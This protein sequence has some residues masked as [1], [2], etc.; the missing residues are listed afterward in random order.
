MDGDGTGRRRAA[1]VPPGPGGP[2]AFTIPL[3]TGRTVRAITPRVGPAACLAA[4]LLAVP[5]ARAVEPPAPPEGFGPSTFDAAAPPAEQYSRLA[6]EL[7]ETSALAEV[8]GTER[9]ALLVRVIEAYRGYQV[10]R[11]LRLSG[12]EGANARDWP[13]GSRWLL[14]LTPGSG[15]PLEI[16]P[17]G[18][19]NRRAVAAWSAPAWRH[20]PVVVLA[21]IA[22]RRAP[23]TGD[24]PMFGVVRVLRGEVTEREF[25]DYDREGEKVLPL[26]PGGTLYVLG[27]R[28]LFRPPGSKELLGTIQSMDPV[29]EA[30][31]PEIERLVRE[32]P[33]G[34]LRADLLREKGDLERL[35]T[36]FRFHR[37]PVVAEVRVA[38]IGGE[39]TNLGGTH[40]AYSAE[41]MIRGEAPAAGALPS[42]ERFDGFWEPAKGA[43]A[44]AEAPLPILFYGGGHGYYG[45]ERMGDRFLAAGYGPGGHPSARLPLDEANRAAAEAWLRQ[46]PPPFPC[47]RPDPAAFR[48]LSGCAALPRLAAEAGRDL[49]HRPL[50]LRAALARPERWTLFE[51]HG[52]NG[53]RHDHGFHW[54][55]RC[56]IPNERGWV[57]GWR[58]EADAAAWQF[59]FESDEGPVPWRQGERW[60][61]FWLDAGS[62]PPEG[63]AFAPG[64]FMKDRFPSRDGLQALGERLREIRDA[65]DAP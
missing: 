39:A 35:E 22:R 40:L 53:A 4:L 28:G 20:S 36:A 54:A 13:R 61:G 11:R 26:D 52:V 32:D 21:R 56:G 46:S 34:R 64:L 24:G 33:L 14:A 2:A 47:R 31:I 44:Q 50:S 51:I 29:Q 41:R 18:E 30:G 6:F 15:V 62:P 45:P 58:G 7:G 10:P 23:R 25:S 55:I 17:D 5:A 42:R 3:R 37:A 48:D 49:F 16:L 63:R 60:F 12:F 27:M 19:E 59:E 43:G 9:G 1:A 57:A 38:G 65:K 8:E